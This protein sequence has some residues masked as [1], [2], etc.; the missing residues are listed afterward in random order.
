[1]GPEA[2]RG[3]GEEI[4]QVPGRPCRYLASGECRS[5]RLGEAEGAQIASN[6]QPTRRLGP[7]SSFS[8]SRAG[9]TVVVT[10]HAEIGSDDWA[11]IE[12]VLR[13]L[14]DAQG[15]LDVLLDLGEVE[16]L[17]EAA[18]PLIVNAA[19]Q[20]HRHGGHLRL[21]DRACRE[22]ARRPGTA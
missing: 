17:E 3:F 22:R 5:G 12:A 21:A 14:I 13:D 19:H 16:S 15:N 8:I 2:V 18:A 10:V 1:M 9:G 4:P 7:A 6:E 20:A 11:R